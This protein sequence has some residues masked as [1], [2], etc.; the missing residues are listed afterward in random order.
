MPEAGIVLDARSILLISRPA[1]RVLS[2]AEL[3]A[4]VAHESVTS[5]SGPNSSICV[6]VAT[7]ERGRNLSCGAMRLPS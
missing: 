7:W 3:Q 4:V 2:T 5:T 1:L 6:T